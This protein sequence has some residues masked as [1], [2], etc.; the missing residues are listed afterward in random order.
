M[1]IGSREFDFNRAVYLMGILNVTPDSF[2]D[3]GLTLDPERALDHALKMQ[4][5]GADLVDVGAESTRPGSNPV[6]ADEEL[7]RLLPVLKKIIPR[8]KIP[9]SV[10]TR[11]ASVGEG[12]LKEGAALIN[13]VS[14][15]G[16]PD[17]AHAI[18]RA[19]V[20]VILMHM[21]GE[22][23]TMQRDVFYEDPVAEIKNILAERVQFAV[24]NGILKERILIDP[25]IGF[26]KRFEDNQKILKQLGSFK[27][28]GCPLVFGA[29]RKSFVRELF[30]EDR[31]LLGSVL[32]AILA[33][34][35]GACLLR[36]HDVKETKSAIR[37]AKS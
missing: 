33:A 18:A 34:Q 26:G 9:V 8:L 14:A 23:R 6:P 32:S 1:R 31:I 29:S 20:P 21:R 35:R 22:P 12:A 36:V 5:E 28:L 11:K 19:G 7:K 4:E 2:S 10:D 37:L 30:G 27:D 16:D 24:K 25:G 17:M 15:L 3:G 13:D